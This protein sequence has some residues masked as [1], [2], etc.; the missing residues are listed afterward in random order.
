MRTQATFVTSFQYV[1]I[2]WWQNKSFKNHQK[3]FIHSLTSRRLFNPN[4]RRIRRCLKFVKQQAKSQCPSGWNFGSYS[5]AYSQQE[6]AFKCLLYLNLRLCYFK[7]T[8]KDSTVQFTS[9]SEHKKQHISHFAKHRLTQVITLALAV[10]AAST[11]ILTRCLYLKYAGKISL[12]REPAASP[13]AHK[14]NPIN[15]V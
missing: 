11:Q 12:L 10:K 2:I 14:P 5:R 15:T 3:C 8:L 4:L 6:K 1:F 7:Q 13:W 9:E